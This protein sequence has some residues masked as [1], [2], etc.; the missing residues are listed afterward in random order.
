MKIW[1]LK[2]YCR[3]TGELVYSP[4]AFVTYGEVM[5]EKHLLEF[6]NGEKLKY[7]I[8]EGWF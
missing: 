3:K 7:V 2:G 6:D 5:Q 1:W 8:T 4:A